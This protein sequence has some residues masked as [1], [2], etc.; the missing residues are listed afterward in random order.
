M[1]IEMLHTTK[2]ILS[3]STTTDPS[4]RHCIIK[5]SVLLDFP[6]KLMACVSFICNSDCKH[7]AHIANKLKTNYD[8][9]QKGE[10]SHGISL[11]FVQGAY[12]ER[13]GISCCCNHHYYCTS[14]PYVFTEITIWK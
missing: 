7:E 4:F 11:F 10:M 12:Q 9:I 13:L 14:L 8:T 5:P 6:I 1:T 3:T 2:P